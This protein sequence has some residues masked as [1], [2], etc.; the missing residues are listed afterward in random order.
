VALVLAERVSR[1]SW[2]AK[3]LDRERSAWTILSS[4]CAQEEQALHLWLGCL[5]DGQ[6]DLVAQRLTFVIGDMPG[7]DA[8][9]PN[10]G[11]ATDEELWAGNPTWDKPFT[12]LAVSRRSV[13]AAG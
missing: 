6:V 12:P 3:P 11:E 1:S 4:D 2:S 13:S 8:A 9:P 5:P 7:M 10:Y